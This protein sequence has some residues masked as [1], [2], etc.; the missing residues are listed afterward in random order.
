MRDVLVEQMQ[1][2][3]GTSRCG[4]IRRRRVPRLEEDLRYDIGQLGPDDKFIFFYAG[5]GF[6]AE[7]ANRLATWDTHAVHI[8]ETTTCLDTVLLSPLKN[9]KCCRSLM[10]ID[11]CATTFGDADKLGR[12]RP[13]CWY[14]RRYGSVISFLVHRRYPQFYALMAISTRV[15][16]SPDTLSVVLHLLDSDL[17][18]TVAEAAARHLDSYP[19]S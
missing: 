10:F 6:Y 19:P 11:A 9:G 15:S 1:V 14:I 4:R 17:S 13:S 5:H 2:P 16:Y 7:G 12:P 8:A 18:C 3:P